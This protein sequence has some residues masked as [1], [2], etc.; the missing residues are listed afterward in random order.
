MPDKTALGDRMKLYGRIEAGRRCLPLLPICA[1]IDGKRFSRFT[2][3]LERPYDQRLSRLM[4]DVTRFPDRG[5]AG[6][7]RLHPVRRDQ[8]AV[9][10]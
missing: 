7:R 3:G 2:Q 5:I 4:V 8:P 1:R 6:P 10:Q 9:L